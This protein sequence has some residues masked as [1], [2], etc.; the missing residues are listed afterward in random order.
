MVVQPEAG[1]GGASLF[2]FEVIGPRVPVVDWAFDAV[3]S[4]PDP[5]VSKRELNRIA[6]PSA[7]WL[8]VG[9]PPADPL[10]WVVE[11]QWEHVVLLRQGAW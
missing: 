9:P 4:G 6:R 7:W 11:R 3:I 8:V 10:L 5:F 2:E 1:A